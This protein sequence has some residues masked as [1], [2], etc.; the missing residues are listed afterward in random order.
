[1]SGAFAAQRRWFR[2]P[3]DPGVIGEVDLNPDRETFSPSLAALVFQEG[4]GGCGLILHRRDP[5]AAKPKAGDIIVV[6]LGKVG[7]IKAEIAW[8][9]D[10]DGDTYKMGLKYEDS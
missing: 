5:T 4:Y 1:M 2:F 9:K 10:L 3:A 8:I 7:P 6:R